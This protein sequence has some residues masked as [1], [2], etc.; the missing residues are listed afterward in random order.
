MFD[1]PLARCEALK[2]T[3]RNA[4]AQSSADPISARAAPLGHVRC[5]SGEPP[6]GTRPVAGIYDA[7]A[8]CQNQTSRRKARGRVMFRVLFG[9]AVRRVMLPLLPFQ[10]LIVT[11][12]L[13]GYVENQTLISS[14]WMIAFAYIISVLLE[15][16][17]GVRK[18]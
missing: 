15:A 6:D 1:V 2:R 14:M 17:Y 4:S 7:V 11:L 9:E 16:A 3:K 8:S 10:L 5:R 13:A 18:Q 12:N